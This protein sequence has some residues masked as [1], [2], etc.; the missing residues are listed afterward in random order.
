VFIAQAK[1]VDMAGGGVFAPV[2]N[3]NGFYNRWYVQNCPMAH[4]CSSA[5]SIATSRNQYQETT[6]HTKHI[7]HKTTI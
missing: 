2:L 3:D 6:T 7:K 4:E 1:A 5:A